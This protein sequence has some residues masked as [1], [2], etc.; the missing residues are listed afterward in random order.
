MART[1][2]RRAM[3]GAGLLTLA[4]VGGAGGYG[5]GL[6]LTEEPSLAGTA[7]P[8]AVGSTPGTTPTPTPTPPPRKVTYDDSPALDVDDLR[9]KSQTFDVKSV[10][11]SR[12]S[13]RI[14]SGWSLTQPDPPKTGRFTDPTGKRWIRI[15]AGF[16][17]KRPP[18][19]SMQA[20]IAELNRLP[21]NQMLHLISQRVDARYATIAYTYVPPPEQSPEG[22]LRYVI[23]RWVA[24]DSGNC[25]VEMSSTG[26]P[27]DKDALLDVLDHA[28]DS[29]ERRDTPLSG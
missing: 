18:V 2:S 26:L 24:D 8:L 12:V 20:R 11:K 21:A 27:Q 5:V 10:V 16:T 17:I 22:V 28:A 3:L 1:V 9:Y 13:V 14:P 6:F 23:V 19:T 7:A 15:E 4:G 29:V 25:A